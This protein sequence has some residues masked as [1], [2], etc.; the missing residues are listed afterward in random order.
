MTMHIVIVT[1]NWPP[2]NAIGTHRP[3]SWA[4][5]WSMAGAK[6]TV[7]TAVK[8][9]YDNPLDLDLPVLD[10]VDVIEVPFSMPLA[11]VS[12]GSAGTG[13]FRRLLKS[14][15]RS[16]ARNLGFVFDPRDG[17]IGA[18]S[19]E[20]ER[21]A[22]S[23]DI[24]V[25]TFGP[26][27][28]HIVADRMKGINGR[29][30]WVA[31][32]RDLWSQNHLASYSPRARR[33]EQKKEFET[34]GANADL[35]TTVSEELARELGAMLG[36]RVEV[37]YNG[38]DFDSSTPAVKPSSLLSESRRIVY[39]GM[40]YEGSRDPTPLFSALRELLDEGGIDETTFQVDFYGPETS[41]LPV[42]VRKFNLDL[43]VNLRG[44]VDRPMALDA[45]RNAGVLLLLESPD[46]AAKG[47]LT[48][49]LF[50]YI[51]AGRPI[52]SLGSSGDSAICRV[53]A[54]T[55]T[56]LGLQEDVQRIKRFLAEWVADGFVRGYS[57]KEEVIASY[58]R[59]QQAENLLQLIRNHAA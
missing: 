56:G 18:A 51:G 42:L 55:G 20:I 45:Q 12:P 24:V 3:Y 6:I 31:D 52:L 28:S 4:K 33:A 22:K 7:L 46:V 30:L 44:A 47:V 13:K 37:V 41:W 34:V 32:Y 19:S 10:D 38:F 27:A 8:Q 40:L 54:A 11:G 25:S 17:W 53:L 14:I 29:I 57:P 26:R 23:A 43:V 15:K 9:F 36:R 21:L 5:Y 58:S 59:R 2:R 49:K 35:V 50:E 16:L 39:T 1:Y 48:G